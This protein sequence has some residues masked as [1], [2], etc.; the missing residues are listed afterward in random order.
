MLTVLGFGI[1]TIILITWVFS[2]GLI[3]HFIIGLL[4]PMLCSMAYVQARLPLHSLPSEV[5][6]KSDSGV[7]AHYTATRHCTAISQS[8]GSNLVRTLH[9]HLACCHGLSSSGKSE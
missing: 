3:A 1:T 7:L 4:F 5:P 6:G 9:F 8:I 2:S